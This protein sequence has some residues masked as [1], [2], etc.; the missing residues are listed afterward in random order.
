M[1]IDLSG[2]S[3]GVTGASRGIGRSIAEH[4][5]NAGAR[6]G[7][8]CHKNRK[9]ADELALKIGNGSQVFSA[10]LSKTDDCCKLF[11]EMAEAFGRIDCWVNNAGI[12]V[13]APVDL[14]AGDWLAAWEKTMRVN[15]TAA[16]I[17][18][19]AAIGHFLKNGVGR[20]INI[21]SRAAFRGDQTE[22]LAYAASKG[23]IVSL[24]RSIARGFGKAGILAF[25]IAPG[26]VRT[27]MAREFFEEY[28]ENFALNDIALSRL[29][30]PQDLA[31]IVTLLAS[32]LADHAT[33]ATIDINAA[34]Y[35]H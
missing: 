10:D 27:D 33:G 12:A 7:I 14:A 16:A 25:I 32:G 30:E 23:G 24:T 8:H 15:L 31:P 1:K 11:K 18:C 17:L 28:G 9:M 22:Y 13:K 34:S 3:I 26:F 20:I 2:M 35:V 29:T 21:S 19:Q 6:V 4:L 5:A